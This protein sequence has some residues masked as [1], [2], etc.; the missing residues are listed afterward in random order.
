MFF[1]TPQRAMDGYP[2]LKR[3]RGWS[4]RG[5]ARIRAV[6]SLVERGEHLL[7]PF[8]YPP[9]LGAVL[10]GTRSRR[11]RSTQCFAKHP[12]SSHQI[13]N[14]PSVLIPTISSPV[15]PHGSSL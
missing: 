4:C 1:V 13:I 3:T 11:I 7:D 12:L 2:S 15:P 8:S 9:R 6:C 10:V 5:W 14:S